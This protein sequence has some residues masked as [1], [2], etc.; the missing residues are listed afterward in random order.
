MCQRLP[1]LSPGSKGDQNTWAVV[2]Y[3]KT[4]FQRLYPSHTRSDFQQFKHIKAQ[5]KA[6]QSPD[7]S[8]QVFPDLLVGR[9]HVRMTPGLYGGASRH[10]NHNHKGWWVGRQHRFAKLTD[11]YVRPETGATRVSAISNMDIQQ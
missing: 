11:R 9:L 1:E 2:S 5:F 4:R 6:S 8:L 3:P 10:L 7:I